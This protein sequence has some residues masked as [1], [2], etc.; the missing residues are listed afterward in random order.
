MVLLGLPRPRQVRA[1][2]LMWTFLCFRVNLAHGPCLS[3]KIHN[4]HIYNVLAFISSPPI[5]GDWQP[6]NLLAYAAIPNLQDDFDSISSE[7]CPCWSGMFN[8]LQH[9]L[10][11]CGHR[12]HSHSWR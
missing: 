7:I 9:Q 6:S 2:L 12:H 4:L 5:M 1:L 10:H 11:H 8:Y 3:S